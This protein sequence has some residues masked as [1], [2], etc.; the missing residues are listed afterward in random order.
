MISCYQATKL[1]SAQMD[2][3][4]SIEDKETLILHL[5]NC[6]QCNLFEK[7]MVIIAAS[8]RELADETKVFMKLPGK[9]NHKSTKEEVL[10]VIHAR[11][12]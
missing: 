1:I 9:Y 10:T 8:V 3:P 7:Q 12:K 6:R 5:F 4:L 11:N 2:H